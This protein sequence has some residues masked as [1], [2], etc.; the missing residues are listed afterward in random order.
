MARTVRRMR[1]LGSFVGVADNVGDRFIHGR[2]RSWLPVGR[3]AVLQRPVADV[4]RTLRGTAIARQF[5]LQQVFAEIGHSYIENR[6]RSLDYGPNVAHQPRRSLELSN[7]LLSDDGGNFTRAGPLASANRCRAPVRGV[8]FVPVSRP[9]RSC[10]AIMAYIRTAG[11]WS[12][13][14]LID[15]VRIPRLDDRQPT[16]ARACCVGVRKR[17]PPDLGSGLTAG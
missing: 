5:Q 11:S 14:N 7:A 13:S 10:N 6:L 9:V 4:L 16:A 3:S 1:L 15:P 17:A 12:S 2:A 8:E